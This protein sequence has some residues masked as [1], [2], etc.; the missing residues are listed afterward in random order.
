MK[1]TDIPRELELSRAH[2]P[3]A[4]CAIYRCTLCVWLVAGVSSDVSQNITDSLCTRS[5]LGRHEL[6]LY[7]P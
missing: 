4:H 3:H 7:L 6:L 1:R 5:R 2:T